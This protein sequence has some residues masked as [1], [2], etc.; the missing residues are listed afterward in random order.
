MYIH[1]GWYSNICIR[2]RW[3]NNYRGTP[4]NLEPI[5]EGHLNKHDYPNTMF[6]YLLWHQWLLK[7]RYGSLQ[8][9]WGIHSSI[10]NSVLHVF[11][12]LTDPTLIS[13]V[14]ATILSRNWGYQKYKMS[15]TAHVERQWDLPRSTCSLG[16]TFW[17]WPS[18]SVHSTQ[19][20]L[21][22]SR[23]PHYLC[24]GE[25]EGVKEGGKDEEREWRSEG[26]RE[27]RPLYSEHSKKCICK[28][29]IYMYIPM[30]A[31]GWMKW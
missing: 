16:R 12:W 29:Y 2:F 19:M 14:M 8:A 23:T 26:G 22:Q 7:W 27:W 4:S 18:T 5:N 20:H 24:E 17:R 1:S 15:V 30:S 11:R 9:K 6:V 28:H 25:R 10:M 3:I 13:L 21:S 31:D